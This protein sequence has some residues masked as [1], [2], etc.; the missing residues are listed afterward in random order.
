MYIVD[1]DGKVVY[2]G[3]IDDDPR[4]RKESPLNYVDQALE[5]LVAGKAVPPP[6]PIRTAAR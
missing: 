2:A 4:G 3:A 1:G 6:A 5:A